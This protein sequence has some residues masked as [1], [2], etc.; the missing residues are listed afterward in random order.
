[1]DSRDERVASVFEMLGG[2][3]AVF[4]WGRK[5]GNNIP[6]E[7][8]SRVPEA[9]RTNCVRLLCGLSI[10]WNVKS[11]RKLDRKYATNILSNSRTERNIREELTYP[12]R[13]T[14]ATTHTRDSSLGA[15]Y[16]LVG[17]DVT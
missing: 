15:C 8:T 3:V 4:E 9:M 14:R 5:I 1:M 16:E 7:T 17:S 11:G 6:G 13:Y 2:A 10:P 12:S